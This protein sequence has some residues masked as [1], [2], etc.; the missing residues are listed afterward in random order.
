MPNKNVNNN[1]YVELLEAQ[2][3]IANLNKEILQSKQLLNVQ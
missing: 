1:E 3:T 2:K